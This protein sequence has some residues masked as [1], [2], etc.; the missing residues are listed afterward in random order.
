MGSAVAEFLSEHH[1][2]QIKRLGINDQFGQSGEP[3]ELLAYYGLDAT[4][5]QDAA[6]TLIHT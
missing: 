2:V 5:I 3:N 6:H 4:H 1:P